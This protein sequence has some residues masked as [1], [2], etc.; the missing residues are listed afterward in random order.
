MTKVDWIAL[1]LFLLL[2]AYVAWVIPL[3]PYG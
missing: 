2:V 1:I 3:P